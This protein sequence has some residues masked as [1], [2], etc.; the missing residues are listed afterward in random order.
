[1]HKPEVVVPRGTEVMISHGW[2]LSHKERASLHQRGS[3][4]WRHTM[5][6]HLRHRKSSPKFT[7]ADQRRHIPALHAAVKVHKKYQEEE[8]E[9]KKKTKQKSVGKTQWM[10]INIIIMEIHERQIIFATILRILLA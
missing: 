1:M 7:I 5:T 3:E 10:S 4:L 8:E 9:K 6:Q 2:E